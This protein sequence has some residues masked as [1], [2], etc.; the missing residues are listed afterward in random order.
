[1]TGRLLADSAEPAAGVN[2]LRRSGHSGIHTLARHG[3][4]EA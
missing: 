1:M 4:L 3:E 2:V